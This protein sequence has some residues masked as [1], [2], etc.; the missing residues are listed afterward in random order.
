MKASNLI[1]FTLLMS[2]ENSSG[3]IATGW[4][5]RIQFPAV[6]DFSLFHSVQTDTGAHPASYSKGIE[7][8]FSGGKAAGACN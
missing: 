4:K 2:T 5:S 6:Q 8:F 3:G 1:L 7:S